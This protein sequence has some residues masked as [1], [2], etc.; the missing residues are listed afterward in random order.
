MWASPLRV[1]KTL[2]IASQCAHWRGNPF[3]KMSCF[4]LVLRKTGFLRER[5]PTVASLPR[6]DIY[7]F[8]TLR[9]DVGIDLCDG[10]KLS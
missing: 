5:I 10:Q 2:V 4:Y 1:S 7:F 3:S 6:N 8:D 9:D